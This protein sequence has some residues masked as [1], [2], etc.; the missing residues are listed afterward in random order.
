[1]A[2]QPPAAR[3]ALITMACYAVRVRRKYKRDEFEVIGTIGAEPTRL[4]ETF[5]DCLEKAT[6]SHSVDEAQQRLLRVL[7][8]ERR[9][10]TVVGVVE[11]GDYGYSADGINVK[12]RRISFRRSPEDA[13]LL[14]FYFRIHLPQE[15]N[16]GILMVQR[17]GVTGV[18][19]ELKRLLTVAFEKQ[20]GDRVLVLDRLVPTEVIKE[21]MKGKLLEVQLT[22]YSKPRDIADKF[23]FGGNLEAVGSLT[24]IARAK[25]NS[26]LPDPAWLSN[27][28]KQRTG[29]VTVPDLLGKETTRARIRVEY[30]GTS[31]MVDLTDPD[32]LAPY[33][34]ISGDVAIDRNGHPKFESI[35]T[36]AG[37]LQ[38]DLL[39]E[40]GRA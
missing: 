29:V 30:G 13:E 22:T 14:P 38:E 28:R 34:D 36:H 7:R 6:K 33:I 15:G 16:M 23:R 40:L 31:R 2:A 19:G 39:A 37:K 26:Y 35:D 5:R 21:L 20:F 9:K 17:F 27:I 32:H 18:Y 10:D 3:Q 11:V 8:L 1:V 12:T 4:I 25:R 24:I